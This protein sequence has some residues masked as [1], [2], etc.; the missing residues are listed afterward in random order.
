MRI[1]RIYTHYQYKKGLMAS[2]QIDL[3]AFYVQ[4]VFSIVPKYVQS[5]YSDSFLIGGGLF[6]IVFIGNS[7]RVKTT[8]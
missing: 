3:L 2:K 7:R 4:A 6:M 5:Y 1:K 8:V